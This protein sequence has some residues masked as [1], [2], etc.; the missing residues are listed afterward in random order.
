MKTYVFGS[1][2]DGANILKIFEI[3]KL[4]LSFIFLFINLIDPIRRRFLKTNG[5]QSFINKMTKKNVRFH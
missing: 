1:H 3:R 4:C 5:S 2:F